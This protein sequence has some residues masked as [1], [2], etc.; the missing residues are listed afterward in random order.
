MVPAALSGERSVFSPE[1]E[2]VYFQCSV[3][4][5]TRGKKNEANSTN[6]NNNANNG[7]CKEYE[8]VWQLQ[9]A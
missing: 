2:I 9:E 5:A 4:D 6:N 1:R 3:N 8:A 7:C